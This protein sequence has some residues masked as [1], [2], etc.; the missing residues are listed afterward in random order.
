MNVNE[1]YLKHRIMLIILI[2]GHIKLILIVACADVVSFLKLKVRVD[3]DYCYLIL[4]YFI[5]ECRKSEAR[6]KY[7]MVLFRGYH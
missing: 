1:T 2:L 7:Y 3:L 4:I 6:I 5:S